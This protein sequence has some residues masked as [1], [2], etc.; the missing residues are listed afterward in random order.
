MKKVEIVKNSDKDHKIFRATARSTRRK[1]LVRTNTR[2]GI[3]M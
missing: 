1:N 2:G 3:R